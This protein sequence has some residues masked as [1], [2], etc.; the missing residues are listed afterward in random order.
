MKPSESV[1]LGVLLGIIALACAVLLHGPI[2]TEQVLRSMQSSGVSGLIST[3][4][5]LL[6]WMF[7]GFIFLIFAGAACLVLN[8]LGVLTMIAEKILSGISRAIARPDNKPLNSES[9]V[10]AT[11]TGTPVTL[12]QMLNGLAMKIRAL[13][14]KTAGLEPPPPPK[15]A[16]ETIA[17]L[18]AELA[19]ARA[20]APT[21][22]ETKV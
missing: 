20:V 14:A 18:Q 11:K 4:L 22:V 12:G 6:K 21:S 5:L 15:S 10:G 2:D 3:G 1:K 9:I 16:E 19:K 7:Y 17:E 8:G 13:E